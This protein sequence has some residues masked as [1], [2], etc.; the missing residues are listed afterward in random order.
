MGRKNEKKKKNTLRHQSVI[1]NSRKP[2]FLV[3][4][5]YV[6]REIT[7]AVGHVKSLKEHQKLLSCVS[8]Y[9]SSNCRSSKCGPHQ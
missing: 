1:R 6:A 4:A 8:Y 2:I 3:C 7:P 5:C 9:D